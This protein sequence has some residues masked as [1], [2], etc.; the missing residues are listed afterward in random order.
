MEPTEL[1]GTHG[2][3]RGGDGGKRHPVQ[4][5]EERIARAG[6]GG[7][8]ADRRCLVDGPGSAGNAGRPRVA[9]A[10]ITR[11]LK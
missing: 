3:G 10:A 5:H 11:N 4:R 8:D 2:A 7:R 1:H 9:T 6:A